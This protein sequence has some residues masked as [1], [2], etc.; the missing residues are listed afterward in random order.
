MKVDCAIEIKVIPFYPQDR[1][2]A[3]LTERILHY[4]MSTPSTY[5]EVMTVLCNHIDDYHLKEIESMF[6]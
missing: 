2:K 3:E 4:L 1:D 5:K 6:V